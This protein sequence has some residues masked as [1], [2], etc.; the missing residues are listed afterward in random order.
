MRI[1]AFETRQARERRRDGMRRWG[2]WLTESNRGV[3]S[4]TP[5][6]ESAVVPELERRLFPLLLRVRERFHGDEARDDE[7]GD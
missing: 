7:C 4:G 5:E 2:K 6:P 1:L 3:L